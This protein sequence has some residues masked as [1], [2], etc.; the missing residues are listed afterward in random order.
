MSFFH[1]WKY[2][3]CESFHS[4]F[5]SLVDT[6]HPNPFDFADC[7]N[8]MLANYRI[9]FEKLIANPDQPIVRPRG[10]GLEDRH[11][12]SKQLE[13][14]LSNGDLTPMQFI[15]RNIHSA[16]GLI[17]RAIGP[18]LEEEDSDN[19]NDDEHMIIQDEDIIR[20]V[21]PDSCL[22]CGGVCEVKY[23][24]QCGHQQLCDVCSTAILNEEDPKCP[25]C[26]QVAIMRIRL[27]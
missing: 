17:D 4:Q 12:R 21:N 23:V 10:P 13:R 19:E 22:S 25:R 14:L 27:G 11:A 5:N 16:D 2:N 24:F 18:V 9:E 20:A 15:N 6:K 1:G 3:N 26:D 8:E 7:T